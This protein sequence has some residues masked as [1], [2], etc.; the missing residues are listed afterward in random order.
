MIKA[1]QVFGYNHVV[2][3][4][5]CLGLE[6]FVIEI[7]NASG[8]K[9]KIGFPIEQLEWLHKVIGSAIEEVKAANGRN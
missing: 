5:C 6:V 9:E 8:Q 4:Q 3:E 7:V 1:G 2:I